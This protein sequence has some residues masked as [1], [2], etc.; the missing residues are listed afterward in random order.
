MNERNGF[1]LPGIPMILAVIVGWLLLGYAILTTVQAQ[2][3][4]HPFV[5]F[6]FALAVAL[7]MFVNKGFFQVQPNQGKVLQLFG[8]YTGTVRDEGLHWT[9]PFF[10][11]HGI[12][13]RV[14]AGSIATVI[15]ANGAGKTPSIR[16]IALCCSRFTRAAR[17]AG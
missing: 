13:L 14:E 2:A 15:G 17:T 7:L 5:L 11:K 1:S 10:T 4:P 6:P 8:R 16:I 9:N 3:A 12:S